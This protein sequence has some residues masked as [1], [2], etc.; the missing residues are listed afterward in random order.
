MVGFLTHLHQRKKL[1]AVGSAVGIT[2]VVVVIASVAGLCVWANRPDPGDKLV[3]TGPGYRL[4]WHPLPPAAEQV[5]KTMGIASHVACF[6][7]TMKPHRKCFMTVWQETWNSHASKGPISVLNLSST[8][9]RSGAIITIVAPSRRYPSILTDA[10]WRSNR[11]T[12]ETFMRC[13][14]RAKPNKDGSAIFS[15]DGNFAL[16]TR[17]MRGLYPAAWQG[18]V[19]AIPVFDKSWGGSMLTQMPLLLG[20]PTNNPILSDLPQGT[21]PPSHEYETVTYLQISASASYP[22]QPRLRNGRLVFVAP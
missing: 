12:V 14:Y 11:G 15:S 10:R 19:Q 20:N 6:R 7:I 16:N 3:M 9:V 8:Q 17:A 1:V 5:L 21:K 4:W 18:K 2:A 13:P 22:P